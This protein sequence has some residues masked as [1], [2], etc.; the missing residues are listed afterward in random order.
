MAILIS[1]GVFL[2]MGILSM[3]ESL[4]VVDTLV[5]LIGG[6]GGRRRRRRSS[7]G[8]LTVT[9]PLVESELEA[10]AGDVT[11]LPKNPTRHKDFPLI[12][13]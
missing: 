10:L 7:I 5:G 2:P 6:R 11:I 9:R 13:I 8:G 3:A 4:V 1:T 12:V